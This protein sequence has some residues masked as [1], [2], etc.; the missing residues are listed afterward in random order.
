MLYE[1]N[2]PNFIDFL[3]TFSPAIKAISTIP[4]HS[5]DFTPAH[6]HLLIKTLMS[7]KGIISAIQ[8]PK[9]FNH[10]FEWIYP[11]VFTVLVNKSMALYYNIR[12]PAVLIPL[13]KFLKEFSSNKTHR[14]HFDTVA[15][16]G[17]LIFK[18]VSALLVAL[19]S[20]LNAKAVGK[21]V[22]QEK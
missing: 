11:N 20:M 16:N 5:Q 3:S 12:D 19:F 7:L 18:E 6:K 10:L 13:F 17:F 14:L 8:T 2:Y 22:Y 9:I 1:E 4:E 21:D 15:I